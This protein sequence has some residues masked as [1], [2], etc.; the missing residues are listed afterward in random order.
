MT[1]IIN[2]MRVYA[3]AHN[4]GAVAVAAAFDIALVASLVVK[5][6]V[7]FLYAHTLGMGLLFVF[8]CKRFSMSIV[9]ASARETHFLWC[10]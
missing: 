1:M 2:V 7:Q 9:C 3:Y 6:V 8:L 5:V 10:A 4:G